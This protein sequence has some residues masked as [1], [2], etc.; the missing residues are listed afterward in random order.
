MAGKT[1]T[2]YKDIII[3]GIVSNENLLKALTI[4]DQDF[5]SKSLTISLKD[6]PYNYVYPYRTDPLIIVEPKTIITI[7]FVNFNF[8]G[9]KFKEGKIYFYTICHESLIR[10]DYGNRYDYIYEQLKNIFNNNRT[11][12][13][14]KAIM[15]ETGDLSVS[16][17]QM[18]NVCCLKLSDFGV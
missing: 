9:V 15:S 1:F 16:N 3:N 4:N 10:C 12:G 5:L 6:I 8:D 14:G 7:A 18:G 11:L 17:T 2:E 13:I